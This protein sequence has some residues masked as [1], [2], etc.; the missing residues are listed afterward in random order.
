MSVERRTS[1]FMAKVKSNNIME[2]L[3]GKLGKQLFIRHMRDGRTF[4]LTRPDF[5][6][7][8]FSEEQLTHQSRLQQAAAYAKV[9]AKDNPIYAKKAAGTAKN[10]YNVAIGDWFHPPVIHRIE[11]HNG[12]IRVHATD[13]V[14]VTKVTVTILDEA[15]QCLE[16][17]EAE[18][19]LGVWWGY[20]AANRGQIRVEARDL[21]GNVTRQEY[22]PP[23]PFFSFW[24][25]PVNASNALRNE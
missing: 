14:M 17:G 4:V 6:N 11:W 23:S 1:G 19:G 13:D 3:S 16:Q 8:V 21:A 10:A 25:R 7:R 2:G 12:H 20:S 15:G 22:W 18:L 9:A 5:S 24:E